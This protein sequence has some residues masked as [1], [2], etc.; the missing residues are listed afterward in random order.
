MRRMVKHVAKDRRVDGSFIPSLRAT[1]RKTMNINP[2]RPRKAPRRRVIETTLDDRIAMDERVTDAKKFAK[3]ST[4]PITTPKIQG[5]IS[6][7]PRG[8]LPWI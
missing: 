8:D 5:V 3:A 1:N 6:V 4:I 7:F 2:S